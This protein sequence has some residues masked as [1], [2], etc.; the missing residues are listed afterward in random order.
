[1]SLSRYRN[2]S[3]AMLTGSCSKRTLEA[4]RSGILSRRGDRTSSRT[5]VS[6]VSARVIRSG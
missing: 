5:V 1:M 2:S 6:P 3:G 4:P